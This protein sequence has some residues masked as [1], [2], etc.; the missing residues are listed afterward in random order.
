MRAAAKIRATHCMARAIGLSGRSSTA[1][2]H[3]S[4]QDP[5]ASRLP[6]GGANRLTQASLRRPWH[7]LALQKCN[8]RALERGGE[9]TVRPCAGTI[10]F[11]S[12]RVSTASKA[13]L[14]FF[15]QSR[16]DET[17]CLRQRCF[18]PPRTG[19]S[20]SGAFRAK[21]RKWHSLCGTF[22]GLDSRRKL[23][24]RGML[25]RTEDLN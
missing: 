11:A 4:A 7:A 24:L 13:N 25:W 23:F 6:T 14:C 1:A 19:R 15:S 21:N 8:W 10:Y 12:P 5:A 16:T 2:S 9:E 18:G 17:K 22:P 20:V 3:I